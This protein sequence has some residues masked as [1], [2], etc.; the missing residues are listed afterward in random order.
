MDVGFVRQIGRLI[1]NVHGAQVGGIDGTGKAVPAIH[2]VQTYS[3]KGAGKRWTSGRCRH[4]EKLSGRK[5]R[6]KCRIVVERLKGQPV[7]QA[8]QYARRIAVAKLLLDARAVAV[9]LE[10]I[11]NDVDRS[12][13]GR[14]KPHG[15]AQRPLIAAV[16]LVAGK[17]IV[18]EAIALQIGA[19]HAHTDHVAQR[20]VHHAIHAPAVVIA[21]FHRTLG[22]DA[23]QVRLGR[24][25]VQH[26]RRRVA[27]KKRSL[28]PAQNFD[29]LHVEIIGFEKPGAG[30]RN[31][32]HMD[33]KRRV[34]RR[35]NGGIAYATNGKVG[36][37]EI[38]FREGHVRQC[39]LQVRC[40]VD[41]LL[42]QR[43]GTERR[44]RNRHI[45]QT[46]RLALRRH[47]NIFNAGVGRKR[48]LRKSRPRHQPAKRHGRKQGCPKRHSGICHGKSSRIIN[49]RLCD[50]NTLA[51]EERFRMRELPA[52]PL[53]CWR[54]S[55]SPVLPRPTHPYNQGHASLSSQPATKTIL[56]QLKRAPVTFL[57]RS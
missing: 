10:M 49:Q 27:A 39:Q 4:C 37:R 28:R 54:L 12:V 17:Q 29:A 45:L 24:D 2:I 38:A 26:A 50:R 57:Q 11:P 14:L 46:L 30:K 6:S 13:V 41:L 23:R 3:R 7:W 33:T 56:R 34:A 40:V 15:P 32:V 22:L 52:L 9:L 55:F 51:W 48:L 31:I 16:N 35:R 36:T 47:D 18:R 19:R 25:E 1:I 53:L 20:H 5:C 43:L 44:H 42:L 8:A 21:I